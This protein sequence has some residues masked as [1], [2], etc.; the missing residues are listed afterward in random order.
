M[1]PALT[2]DWPLGKA[3]NDAISLIETRVPAVS[4]VATMPN[5]R[6]D[7]AGSLVPVMDVGFRIPPETSIYYVHPRS[8]KDWVH[9]AL[10]A[11]SLRANVVLSIFQGLTERADIIPLIDPLPDDYPG[12]VIPSAVAV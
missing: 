6:I 4:I 3:A 5:E 7:P 11:V 10:H 12:G 8:D 1:A 9:L 2:A